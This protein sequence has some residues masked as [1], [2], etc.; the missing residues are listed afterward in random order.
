[1]NPFFID[2]VSI[3]HFKSIKNIQFDCN[4]VN[5]LIGKPNVGKSNILE[6]LSLHSLPDAIYQKNRLD[7][8][9]DL[10]RCEQLNN[11]FYDNNKA[12]IIH[13]NVNNQYYKY[14]LIIGYDKKQKEFNIYSGN[15]DFIHEIIKI[16]SK[17]AYYTKIENKPQFPQRQA[18]LTIREKGLK[19]DYE[20]V[21]N[22]STHLSINLKKYLFNGL[23]KIDD[24]FDDFLLPPHGTNLFTILANT[25][26]LRKEVAALF[27]LYRLELLLDPAQSKLDIQK[28][29]DGLVYK[30]PFSLMADTLQRMI[31]HLAAI[32]S[33]HDSILLFEEPESHAFPPY[34]RMLAEK[35]MESKN[36]QFF[37]TTHS[38]YLFNTI[39]ENRAEGEVG[40]FIVDFK[41]HQ[42][43]I[44]KLNEADIDDLA[45]HGVDVFFNLNWFEHD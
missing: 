39:I 24:S 36:N 3:E 15:D 41:D 13:V 10:V 35:I 34:V 37:I 29:V 23:S 5:L 2:N 16:E 44:H 43:I 20:L 38:P 4:R 17:K 9:F 1:M 27:E 7:A 28:R 30:V 32:A 40:V 18:Y 26:I 25:P 45:N 19:K 21:N 6:A 14:S 33:N 42:T 31:F 22:L 8:L 11:L 12:E